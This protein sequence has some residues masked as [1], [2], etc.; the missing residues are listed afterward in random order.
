MIFLQI[1]VGIRVRQAPKMLYQL[2]LAVEVEMAIDQRDRIEV[3]SQ[4][5]ARAAR[6]LRKLGGSR[7]GRLE[8]SLQSGLDGDEIVPRLHTIHSRHLEQQRRYRG[9]ELLSRVRL[10]RRA[11]QRLQSLEHNGIP[12]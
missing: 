10:D 6:V 11:Q 9:F 3:G 12:G 2:D 4:P 1:E 8:Q 5:F 7:S